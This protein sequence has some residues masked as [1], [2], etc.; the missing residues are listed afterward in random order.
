MDAAGNVYVSGFYSGTMTVQSVTLTSR[1]LFD[2]FLAKLDSNGTLLWLKSAGGTGSDIGHGVVVDGQG[3]VGVTGEFQ[4]KATFDS[5]S[6]TAAGLG[7]AFI[8]KYDAAGNNLWV[9]KGGSTTSFVGEPSKAIAVD[10]ANNFLHHG[11][12]HWDSDLRRSLGR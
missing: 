6:V 3:N 7:D 2:I 9:H 5:R 12:L 10:A 4:G 1:G 11:R 8:A